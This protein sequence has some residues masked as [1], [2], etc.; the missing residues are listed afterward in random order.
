MRIVR[1]ASEDEMV[2][3]FLR[4]EGDLT[5]RHREPIEERLRQDGEALGTVRRPDLSDS[6]QCAYRRRLLAELRGFGRGEGMF[7]GFPPRV[8]WVRAAL[9]P[10]EVLEVRYID[11]RGSDDYWVTLSGGSRRP[12]DAAARIRG[13]IGSRWAI[14]VWDLEGCAA[15]VRRL[16]RGRLPELI[17]AATPQQERLVVVEG[18]GRL[19]SFALLADRLPE[20]IEVFFGIAEGLE[21]WGLY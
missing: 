1:P 5:G 10:S 15:V 12:L 8:E 7:I 14:G 13:G 3:A 16:R 21:G 19:T 2:A 6:R 18:N 20:E 4:A 17:V 9:T 11:D